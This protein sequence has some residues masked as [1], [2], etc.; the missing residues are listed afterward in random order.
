M[1]CPKCAVELKSHDFTDHR[2]VFVHVQVCP[3]CKGGWYT[4]GTLDALDESIWTN[5]EELQFT[6]DTEIRPNRFCPECN[7]RLVP[8]HPKNE[9]DLVIDRCLKCKG[10][11]L[12]SGELEQMQ[13]LAH[14]ID[15]EEI[16]EMIH[17]Q[18]P[19]GWSALKWFIYSFK[20]HWKYL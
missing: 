16:D 3:H 8:L 12:D 17:R 6:P 18:K 13:H 14:K 20:E 4:K 7:E 15:A 1:K 10:F 9:S 5:V 2:F 19:A 11:W